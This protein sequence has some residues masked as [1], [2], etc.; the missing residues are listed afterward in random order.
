MT[1]F[2]VW[3]VNTALATGWRKGCWRKEGSLP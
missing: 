2:D 3:F 1:K